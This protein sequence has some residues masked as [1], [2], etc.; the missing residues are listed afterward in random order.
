MAASSNISA[1]TGP[2]HSQ[3]LWRALGLMSGTSLDGI[4]VAIVETDGGQ[5]VISGPSLTIPYREAFRERLRSVLGGIGPRRRSKLSSLAF[6]PTR[7]SN[8]SRA[9]PK[10]ASTSSA[11]TVTPSCIARSSAAPG[12]WVT[13]RCWRRFSGSTSSP[14]SARPTSLRAGEGAPLAPLFHVALAATLPK[15]L[16]SSTSAGLL[17][18]RGSARE[19]QFSPS[20]PDPAT[21]CST[22][23]CGNTPVPRQTSTA[24]SPVRDPLRQ[25]TSRDFWHCLSSNSRRQNHSIA[26]ISAPLCPMIS[27]SRSVP[28]R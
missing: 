5:R 1:E 12:S 9:I 21:R 17:M 25:R 2:Q 7:S 18:S 22:I 6:T 14:I 11:C 4:D 20:T 24:R 3:R 8:L 27:P 10:R 26:T 28:P 15:P 13:G 19:R 16:L 23:G